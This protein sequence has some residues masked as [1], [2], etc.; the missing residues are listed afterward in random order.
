M[1]VSGMDIEE[2]GWPETPTHQKYVWELWPI[3]EDFAKNRDGGRY[4]DFFP[5]GEPFADW[6]HH[7]R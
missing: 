6:A 7:D 4:L 5:G 3:F 2:I 1:R